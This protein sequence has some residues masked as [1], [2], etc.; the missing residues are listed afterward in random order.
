MVLARASTINR[1]S[2]SWKR[3]VLLLL[4]LLLL[5]VHN[6]PSSACFV[7]SSTE[8]PVFLHANGTSAFIKSSNNPAVCGSRRQ[9]T[10]VIFA[11]EGYNVQLARESFEFPSCLGSYIQIRDGPRC[12]SQLIG[13]FCGDERPPPDLCSLGNSLYITF[14]YNSTRDLQMIRFELL[15]REVQCTKQA[16][17]KLIFT[18]PVNS[19]KKYCNIIIPGVMKSGSVNLANF[20]CN[21]LQLLLSNITL[22]TVLFTADVV[23]F[24]FL[25]CFVFFFF[26]FF[27][28]FWL[29]ICV[30]VDVA[31]ITSP[32][33]TPP[34]PNAFAL[35]PFYQQVSL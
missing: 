14:K 30:E 9:C 12:S 1:R 8:E 13:T 21:F 19:G 25:F 20:L 18:E 4:L 10:W 31:I 22:F 27:A 29:G 32:A 26:F 33:P 7:F 34:R 11:H 17:K 28:T 16:Q 24:F 35:L 23:F 5:L 2:T 6:Y 15:Y 3:D